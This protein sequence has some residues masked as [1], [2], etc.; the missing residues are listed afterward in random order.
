MEENAILIA[1][2]TN[3]KRG[4]LPAQ[5]LESKFIKKQWL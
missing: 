2:N 1:E 4:L 3:K 5:R